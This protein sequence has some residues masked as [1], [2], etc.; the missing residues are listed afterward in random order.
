MK[1]D[2]SDPA[3][4]AEQEDLQIEHDKRLNPQTVTKQEATRVIAEVEQLFFSV[5]TL[6][7]GVE[8]LPVESIEFY[9]LNDLGYADSDEFE[10]ALGGTFLEFMKHQMPN[11][12]V[13]TN[14]DTGKEV[15]KITPKERKEGRR[16]K[17]KIETGDDLLQNTFVFA[18]Y[19][20]LVSI[21]EAEFEIQGAEKPARDT[22][23]NHI[24]TAIN[25][26]E[27]HASGLSHAK[28]ESNKKQ[29]A[30]IF[31]AVEELRGF[32]DVN[33]PFTWMVYDPEGQCEIDN[34]RVEVLPLEEA[35]GEQNEF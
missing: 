34:E 35:T 26:L 22:L 28:D 13:W 31:A 9:L 19:P 11:C 7:D 33:Q 20:A 6:G 8:F 27:Q 10:D 24:S 4:H 14:P 5:S 17:F 32:L 23:Y 30:A 3:I 1:I 25:N 2:I 12:T 29:G 18:A 16:L 15:F 21:P